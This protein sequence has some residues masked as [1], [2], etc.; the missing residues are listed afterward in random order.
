MYKTPKRTPG[1]TH[2]DKARIYPK[3]NAWQLE[4]AA[5]Q[6]G[7]VDINREWPAHGAWDSVENCWHWFDVSGETLSGQ[8]I[9]MDVDIGYQDS[10]PTIGE[11]MRQAQKAAWTQRRGFP[12][13]I[14]PKGHSTQELGVLIRTWMM[15]HEL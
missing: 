8:R 15:K 7:I 13:F 14:A 3:R 1:H 11:H 5:I 6:S 9:V 2:H 10:R 12:Y 4:M